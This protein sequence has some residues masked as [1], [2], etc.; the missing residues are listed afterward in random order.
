MSYQLGWTLAEDNPKTGPIPT[1]WPLDIPAARESCK[2]CALLD[3][4]ECYAWYGSVVRGLMSVVKAAAINPARYTLDACLGRA[5]RKR[6]VT[7]KAARIGPIGDPVAA[8]GHQLRNAVRRLRK[9][10]LA[11]LAYTHFWRQKRAQRMKDFAR[12]SCNNRKEA[13][14]AQAKGWAV[15]VLLPWDHDSSTFWVGSTRGRVCP[16]QMGKPITCNDC[17]ACDPTRFS[18][19]IGFIDHSHRARAKRLRMAGE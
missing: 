13:I 5:R 6:S 3:S 2:G 15:S 8:D 14:E 17:R 9:E 1:A 10:G 4:K 16:V 19:P 11:V 7:I 12:A 18:K